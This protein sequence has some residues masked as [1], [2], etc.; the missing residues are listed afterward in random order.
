MSAARTIVFTHLLVLANLLLVDGSPLVIYLYVTVYICV[1][2]QFLFFFLQDLLIEEGCLCWFPSYPVVSL[3]PG[4]P[5][6]EVETMS[7][8][9]LGPR[10]SAFLRRAGE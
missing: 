5:L 3:N 9:P 10:T 1:E 2:E 7:V 6:R 4:F 8:L